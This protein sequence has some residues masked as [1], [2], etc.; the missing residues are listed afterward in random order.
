MKSQILSRLVSASTGIGSVFLGIDGGSVLAQDAIFSGDDAASLAGIGNDTELWTQVAKV[1][2]SVLL[3]FISK[4]A[5]K[6]RAEY[7]LS[8]QN[9]PV[10]DG[11]E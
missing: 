3:W 10:K 9:Q 2:L 6:K 7:K 1:G 8:Q 5:A 11:N 4:Q